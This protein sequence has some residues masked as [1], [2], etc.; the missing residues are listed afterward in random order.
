MSVLIECTCHV[1]QSAK[2]KVCQCG[3]DL[4]KLKRGGKARFWINFK[5]EGKQR[6][7]YVGT[8]IEKARD[9]DG[10]RR[11]QKREGRIFDMIPGKDMTMQ[12]AIKRFLELKTTQNLSSY[13]RVKL[14]LKHITGEFGNKLVMNIKTSELNDYALNRLAQ[15]AS[16]ASVTMELAYASTVVNSAV[17]DN[18]LDPRVLLT[19][20]NTRKI[21][22]RGDNARGR[23][24]SVEEYLSLLNA[25]PFHVKAMVTIAYNCG[26]R[27]GEILGLRWSEIDMDKGFIRLKASRTKEDKAKTIPFNHHVHKVFKGLPRALHHDHVITNSK[28]ERLTMDGA[29]KVFMYA[30]KDAGL[31]YGQKNDNGFSFHDFR[32]T[33]KINALEAGVDKIYRDIILG[34]SL[35]GMDKHY[36]E[37]RISKREDLL[38]EA[39]GKYTLWLDAEI[40]R[41]KQGQTQKLTK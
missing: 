16:K 19:F 30:C 11:S 33:W 22:E 7:E 38:A 24:V 34:H 31:T 28:G 2:N 36:I 5:V 3:Q 4:D 8:S 14:A 23:I 6:R 10:K 35:K 18:Q 9:A 32:G 40:D 13:P 39:M 41:A 27:R 15:G 20:K 17:N 12:K 21:M 25:S 1:K 29:Q 26:M 37:K